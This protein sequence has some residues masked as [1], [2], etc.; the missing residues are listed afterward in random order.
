M[1]SIQFWLLSIVMGGCHFCTRE[2]FSRGL[3]CTATLLLEGTLLH[4]DSFARGDIFAWIV[5]FSRG[6]TFARRHFYTSKR[7][8]DVTF[9][10][11]HFCNKVI[12]LQKCLCTAKIINNQTILNRASLLHASLNFYVSFLILHSI[13]FL[14]LLNK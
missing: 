6:N 1:C 7:F 13:M 10:W 4:G 14:P 3:L 9:V 12:F 8:H 5:T 11:R 2:K